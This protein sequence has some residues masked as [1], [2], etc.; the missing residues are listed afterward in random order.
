MDKKSIIGIGLIFAI[1]VVFSLVNQPSKEEIEASKRKQDSIAQ[2]NV[3]I[4]LQ[5]QKQKEQQATEQAVS[6]TEPV[7]SEKAAQDKVDEYGVFAV[8]AVGEEKFT[9]IENNLMV[10]TFSN[11]GGKIYSIRL[12]NYQTHDSLPLM[13]FDGPKTLFGLNFFAQNRSI[14]TDQLFFE[15]L[16][17]K[18]KTVVTGPEIKRGDEG[19]IKFNKENPG[20]KES[21]TFRLEIAPGKFMEYVYT[22]EYNSFLVDFDLNLQGMNQ[23]IAANQSYLNFNWEYDVPRQE[24]KVPRFG[25]D[26]YTN[27]TYKFFEDEVNNLSQSKSDEENL[28][29]K[30]K[31]IGFKQLFFGSTIIADESFPNAQISQV[32]TADDLKYLANFHADIALPY[33]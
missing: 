18:K 25:E 16:G 4:A 13:L 22:L 17:G 10:I 11:K 9:T 12:K 28:S 27:I 15:Q 32:K 29:T 14:Q 7:S 1:L 31:W 26:R 33:G 20:G 3:E 19:K 2:V 24:R 23:Y 30:V 5:Q 8:A 6:S 21:V